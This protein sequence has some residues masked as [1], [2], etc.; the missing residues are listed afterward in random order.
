LPLHL[1]KLAVGAQSLD[2][3]SRWQASRPRPLKHQTRNMPRRAAE[4]IDGGSIYWVINRF[5]S[6]RQR[7]VGIVEGKRAD[8]TACTD[9]LLDRALVP[10]QGRPVKPFQGWRYLSATDAPLDAP[11]GSANAP[12]LPESLRRELASLGLL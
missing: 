4:I 5:L 11:S 8:G 9:L 6:A 2:D 1:I 3:V 7:V 12:A 10:V